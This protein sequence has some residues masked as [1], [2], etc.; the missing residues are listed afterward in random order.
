NDPCVQANSSLKPCNFSIP[1]IPATQ[2]SVEFLVS[3]ANAAPCACNQ[4][5]YN[6]LAECAQCM[7]TSTL[8]V[9]IRC[10]A[11]YK[12]DCTS[13]GTTFNANA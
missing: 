13:F 8:N 6:V 3:K 12:D 4:A 5:V 1:K 7:T 9:H 11:Q 10:L 2:T